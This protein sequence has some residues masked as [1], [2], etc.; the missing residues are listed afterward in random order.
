LNLLFMDSCPHRLLNR[1]LK[2]FV[3]VA[4]V[5]CSAGAMIGLFGCQ[6]FPPIASALP[7]A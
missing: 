4:G 1:L 3:R 7:I 2:E 6:I 5:D